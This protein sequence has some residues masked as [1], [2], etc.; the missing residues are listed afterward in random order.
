M[1]VGYARV[2]TLHQNLDLQI[3]ALTNAG[4]LKENIFTDKSSGILTNRSGFKMMMRFIR[5]GDTLIVW[6]LDRLYRSLKDLIDTTNQLQERG[7]GF[8]SLQESIDSDSASGRLM[9][10][11]FGA[12]AEFERDLTRE[13]AAAGRD[14]ARARGNTGGRPRF[15]EKKI[16]MAKRMFFSGDP[17]MTKKRIC[18]SLEIPRSTFYRYMVKWENEIDIR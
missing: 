14:A 15:D 8:V 3:D 18:D 11:I 10:H 7:I 4:C 9:F 12:L 5:K 2:S 17:T 16:Q 1:K 13:R 6:K